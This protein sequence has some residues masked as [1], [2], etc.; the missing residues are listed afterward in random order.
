MQLDIAIYRQIL[1]KCAKSAH[2]LFLLKSFKVLI[3][4]IIFIKKTKEKGL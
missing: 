3:F 4:K 1:A 2:L